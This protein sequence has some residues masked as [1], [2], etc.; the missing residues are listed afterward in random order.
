MGARCAVTI[1]LLLVYPEMGMRIFSVA[2]LVHSA[3][4]IAIFFGTFV[5]KIRR[6]KELPLKSVRDIFPKLR[7]E[8]K[9]GLFR[10]WDGQFELRCM[11]HQF[12]P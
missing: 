6:E 5:Q 1:V 11:C 12:D 9:P 8:G 2:Q 10:T 7:I 4:L 3:V